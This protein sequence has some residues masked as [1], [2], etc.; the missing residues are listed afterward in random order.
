[1]ILIAIFTRGY[2]PTYN[3]GALP[4]NVDM[5]KRPPKK[6]WIYHGS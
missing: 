3:W 6:K 1:M 4:A 2:K 5:I